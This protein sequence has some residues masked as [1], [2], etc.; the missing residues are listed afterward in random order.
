MVDLKSFPIAEEEELDEVEDE[1]EFIELDWVEAG[2][3]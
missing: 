2:S 3:C 1:V